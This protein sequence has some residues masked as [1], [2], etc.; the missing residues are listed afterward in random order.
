MS[1][2]LLFSLLA[3]TFQSKK[4]SREPPSQPEVIEET[5]PPSA[6]D[7]SFPAKKEERE[8]TTPAVRGV[9]RFRG[10]S[11]NTFYGQGPVPRSPEILWSYPVGEPMSSLSSLKT[12]T[13][14]WA[15]T[16]WTGQPVIV[17]W[18]DKTWVIFGAFDGAV[19]FVNAETGKD[20]LKPFQTGDIIKGSVAFD[21]DGYPLIYF[22]SR[23]N[24]FRIVA[25]D[26]D[27][28]TLLWKLSAYSVKNRVWN[29]DWD[30]CPL[31]LDD[32]L[33]EGGE[34]S[35]FF[36]I[37]LNRG[38][39]VEG[40]VG[41]EPEILLD[42]PAFDRDLFR[43]IRDRN[44]SIENSPA[45]FGDTVYFANGGGMVY[46]IDIG[47]LKEGWGEFP[48]RFEFWMG[49]D[50]DAS[51]VI[52]DEGKLY[53]CAELERG[54]SRALELGQVVKLDP[55]KSENPVVWSIS[56]P[57]RGKA[58]GGV[59][60]TPALH[61]GVLFVPTNPGDLL[62]V[63]AKTGEVLWKKEFPPH[64]WS[65]PAVVDDVLITCDAG[66]YVRAY[67]VK[68]PRVEP[69][70]VWEARIPGGA[71]IE[72]TPVVWKGKI[73]VGARNGHFYCFGERKGAD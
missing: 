68:N 11:T 57:A 27:S 19:H 17:E 32:H 22:G 70:E 13:K 58:K 35:H 10:N 44:V 48:V 33:F 59:W 73:F 66:G 45:L 2:S 7:Q 31:I 23:D 64:F 72:S 24:H 52:D 60:A 1:S 42:F 21:P 30:C 4:P 67:D 36:I 50:V 16:G 20:I 3:F 71:V 54:L 46:G 37:K 38:Y 65:S 56:V 49:D 28:P 14:R 41:V 18:E 29:D 53:V 43:K 69:K 9:L 40:K 6:G 34:N 61:R 55:E 47:G 25:L 39:D 63:D 51:V 8:E 26:H 62:A 12:E 5:T 15:G